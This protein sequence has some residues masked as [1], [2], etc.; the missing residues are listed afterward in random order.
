M[1][2]KQIE[3]K[4]TFYTMVYMLIIQIV[5]SALFSFALW[6]WSFSWNDVR[7]VTGSWILA[8]IFTISWN[9]FVKVK[10]H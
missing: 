10:G 3:W 8:V 7:Y 6:K 9:F 1:Q 4:Y 5:I 2:L